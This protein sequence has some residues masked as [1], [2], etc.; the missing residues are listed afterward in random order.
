MSKLSSQQRERFA[1]ALE[2]VGDD[3]DILIVLAEMATEDAPELMKKLEGEIAN[4][5]LEAAAKTGHALKGLLSTF[6]TGEPVEG[7]Q[8]LIDSARQDDE[9]EVVHQFATLKPQLHQLVES[10]SELT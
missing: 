5:F 8:S 2:R 6:E 7:L 1:N 10:V 3:E 4:G 9:K